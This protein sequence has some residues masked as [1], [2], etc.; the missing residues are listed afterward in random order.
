[1]KDL[2][3]ALQKFQEAVD[4]TP[5]DHLNRAS[6]LHSLAASFIDR[7]WRLG[8][9]QDLEA[10]LQKHKD[11]ID[12]TPVDHT[13][14]AN[15]L[16]GLAMSYGTWYQRLGDMKDLESAIQKSQEVADMTRRDHPDRAMFGELKDLE[17]TVQKFQEA[18]DITP[19][20]HPDRA[21]QLQSLATLFME[22]YRS[23]GDVR[24]LQDALQKCREAVDL[25]PGDHPDRQAG[26]MALLWASFSKEFQPLYC[27]A[28]YSAA[29][30]L[31]PK[32][33][34]MGH[35]ITVRQDAIRWLDIGGTASAATQISLALSKPISAVEF[36]EQGVATT[37]QQMLQLRPDLD[38]LP[39]EYAEKL[40]KLSYELYSG[41]AD[42]PSRIAR[43]RT[44][45]LQDIRKH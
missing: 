16:H 11:D 17:A 26:Y 28:A 1:M 30:N 24:D 40:Q 34:W 32:L 12:L 22:Q 38:I 19:P 41:R 18:V 35:T 29:F 23:V 4:L 39:S 14:R 31:L 5:E 9:L 15:R 36:F 6:Q 13:E 37:F 3:S 7:Y 25:T 8:D 20:D 44:E 45:L 33:L 10:A 42:D 21:G 43:E 2:E 27:P